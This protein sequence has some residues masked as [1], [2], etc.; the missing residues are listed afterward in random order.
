MSNIKDVVILS[1][2][3][4]PLVCLWSSLG[5]IRTAVGAIAIREAVKR[6]GVDPKGR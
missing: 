1:A 6:A 2:C 4:T 3:R 5:A